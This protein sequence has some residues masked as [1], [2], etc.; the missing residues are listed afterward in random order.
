MVTSGPPGEIT[1][2]KLMGWITA[3]YYDGRKKKKKK[4]ET[5][6]KSVSRQTVPSS[7]SELL[8]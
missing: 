6:H 5:S 8:L 3:I 4:N 1:S 7:D 2:K